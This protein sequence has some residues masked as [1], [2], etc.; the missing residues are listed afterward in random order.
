M[1]AATVGVIGALV[2]SRFLPKTPILRALVLAP[3]GPGDAVA[4][5]GAMPESADAHAR[6]A[7]VGAVGVATSAL[8]PVGKVELDD[9]RALEFEAR[10]VGALIERGT[11]VR[12][13]ETSAGR[14]VVE[15]VE[16]APPSA[17]T[18]G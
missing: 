17:E 3:A 1:V 11:R 6:A 16:S 9:A 7:R 5:G 8:R 14:L 10:A 12:V 2:L 13:V 4:F 18:R 15:P